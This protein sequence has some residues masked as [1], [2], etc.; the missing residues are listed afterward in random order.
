V[1]NV[2]QRLQR[3]QRWAELSRK[4]AP[5]QE[6]S[7][8]SQSTDLASLPLLEFIP[9]AS[10]YLTS[11]TWLR[12]YAEQLDATLGRSVELVFA[13]PPQHS[14]T[15][16]TKHALAKWMLLTPGGRYYY[17]TYSQRRS[18]SVAKDFRILADH[19]GLKPDGR[20]DEWT[21]GLNGSRI[22]FT[23]ID[24]GITG[25]PLPENG[26]CVIDDPIKGRQ[27]AFSRA[28]RESIWGV[29]YGTILTR[30]HPGSSIIC[31]A[32]RWAEDDPS[33]RLVSEWG[34]RYT[35]LQ[36]ICEDAET[37]PCGRR[38]GE[39]LWPE[40]RPL[41]FLEQMRERDPW[42]FAAMYQGSPR[43]R[44]GEVFSG[45]PPRFIHLPTSPWRTAYGVDLAYTAKTQADRSVC[46]RG[47]LFDGTIYLT[48]CRIAQ[49][50]A[51]EFTLTLKAMSSEMSGP[52]RWYASGTEKGSAQFIAQRVPGFKVLT[53]TGDKFVRATPAS[54]AWNAGNIALPAENSPLYGSWVD[55]VIDEVC[56]FTGVADSRDDIVDALAACHDELLSGAASDSE[57]ISAGSYRFGHGRARDAFEDD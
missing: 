13:A 49:V 33:G 32:T 19:L 47:Q 29:L 21:S 3:I 5:V 6:E 57:S 26:V 16:T 22:K 10:P 42:G 2:A 43:P 12:P 37:D 14:K 25:D 4:F 40:E 27:E 55:Q 9:A 41:S 1:G 15:E 23:S 36:A 48:A 28:H 46:L 31:M 34:F 20:T 56:S 38:V 30:R 17:V 45:N 52:L 51:P 7:Q 11:P 35:N 44:G 39:A 53:A 18:D 8:S 54:A 24:G 50:A